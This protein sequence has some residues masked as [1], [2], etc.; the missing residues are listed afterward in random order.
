MSDGLLE[1][2][3]KVYKAQGHDDGI[4]VVFLD[5]VK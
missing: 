4:P 2:E 3:G 5:I 1:A